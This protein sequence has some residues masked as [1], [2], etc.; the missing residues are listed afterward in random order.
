MLCPDVI[1]VL[2]EDLTLFRNASK[3]NYEFLRR[4]AWSD[5][6][7]RLGFDEVNLGRLP[8]GQDK[9]TARSAESMQVFIDVSDLVDY[10]TNLLNP[11]HLESSFFQL[12]RSDPTT[13]FDFD[14]SAIS[15][16]TLPGHG[17]RGSLATL[18]PDD[19]DNLSLRLRLGSHLAHYLRHKLE[20]EQGYTSTVGVSTNKLLSK[21]VGNV[22]KPA[23]QTTLIPPY[24]PNL[25]GESSVT[26]FIDSHDIGQIPGIGF[27]TAQVIRNRLLG[28]EAAFDTGLVYGGTKERVGVKEVRLL[29]EM[30]PRKL[31]A[32]LDG[33]GVPKDLPLKV[34]GLLNGVD[35][36]EVGMAKEVPQQISI[37][38]LA[39]A[40]S[41]R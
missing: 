19:P 7:E 3:E 35:N 38:G 39:S 28:R 9:A 17:Q 18:A 36:T 16:H 11:H 2:G 23:A 21:L 29:S 30:G 33:P 26:S 22:N 40:F 12:S 37:V 6:V 15:G 8:F 31:R 24:H 14:A 5:K 27:K 10:N 1:I 13:G 32:L 25:L 34:W 20:H 4:H 41:A